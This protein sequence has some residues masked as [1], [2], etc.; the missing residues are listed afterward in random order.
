[1]EDNGQSTKCVEHQKPERVDL[2]LITNTAIRMLRQRLITTDGPEC[3]LA[4]Q[5]YFLDYSCF[6][7]TVHQSSL[8][9]PKADIVANLSI[10]FIPSPTHSPVSYGS[11][12]LFRSTQAYSVIQQEGYFGYGG[13]CVVCNGS[14]EDV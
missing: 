7:V 6:D 2:P 14:E 12:V 5:N 4:A 11:V 9:V 10:P 13:P 3:A 1:M 8:D